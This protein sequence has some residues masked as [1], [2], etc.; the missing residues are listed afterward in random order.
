MEL[1][2]PSLSNAHDVVQVLERA[3]QLVQQGLGTPYV[4]RPSPNR[5]CKKGQISNTPDTQSFWRIWIKNERGDDAG[6]ARFARCANNHSYPLGTGAKCLTPELLETT[7]RI[8]HH[9]LSTQ[10][11]IAEPRMAIT[12]LNPHAGE[13]GRMGTEDDAI[14]RPVIEK[15]KAEGLM[16]TGPHPRIPCFMHAHAPNMMRP[17]PCIM[18]RP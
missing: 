7:I 8:T 16:L 14:I 18:I 10:F 4:P 2:H 13:D 9:A 12:G 17:S 11:G 6:L 3:V 15:L 1:G 5:F